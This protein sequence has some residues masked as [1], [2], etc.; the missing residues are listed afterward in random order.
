MI[1]SIRSFS[2]SMDIN[3]LP[4]FNWQFLISNYYNETFLFKHNFIIS[5]TESSKLLTLISIYLRVQL[6]L[7]RYSAIDIAVLKIIKILL[8]F[9]NNY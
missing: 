8:H 1:I 4:I 3:N 6:E 5:K 7:L 9:R 2:F